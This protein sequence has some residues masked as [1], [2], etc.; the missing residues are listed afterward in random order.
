MSLY[1]TGAFNA[2]ARSWAF[3]PTLAFRVRNEPIASLILLRGRF[4]DTT[5]GSLKAP[6][7]FR[8]IHKPSGAYLRVEGGVK[9]RFVSAEGVSFADSSSKAGNLSTG[10]EG[11]SGLAVLVD[12][13]I[14]D[15]QFGDSTDEGCPVPSTV[16][17]LMLRLLREKKEMRWFAAGVEQA[18]FKRKKERRKRRRE[19]EWERRDYYDSRSDTSDEYDIEINFWSGTRVT[20]RS[21][22]SNTHVLSTVVIIGSKS[23]LRST[24]GKS[25]TTR[26]YY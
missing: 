20:I 24:A 26:I 9:W 25:E 10:L 3:A 4:L 7:C 21:C 1:D 12:L 22:N 13:V 15:C 5:R 2:S 19:S 11:G 14:L 17:V 16:V 6:E 8:G 23:T 18:W